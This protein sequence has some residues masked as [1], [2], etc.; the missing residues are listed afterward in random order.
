MQEHRQGKAAAWPPL[1]PKPWFEFMVVR[2]HLVL[3]GVVLLGMV[4]RLN[5]EPYSVSALSSR[6]TLRIAESHRS[7]SAVKGQLQVIDLFSNAQLH[8]GIP[9]CG[10]W[11]AG[12]AMAL[13]STHES[14]WDRDGGAAGEVIEMPP[15]PGSA[16]L[17][18]SALLGMGAWHLA[19]QSRD[20][21][22]GAWPTWYQTGEPIQVRHIVA[23]EMSFVA[24]PLPAV[25]SSVEPKRHWC[26]RTRPDRPRMPSEW[27]GSVVG[28]RAPPFGAVRHV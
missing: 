5:A 21:R 12:E 24:V 4:D 15:L 23:F 26:V 20:F 2:V 7:D 18:L 28:P 6:P 27:A 10:G 11:L 8:L 1:I 25:R 19:R 13:P 22:L 9:S 16:E 14:S 3:A 17:F